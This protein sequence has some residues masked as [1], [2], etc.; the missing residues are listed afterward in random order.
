MGIG[1]VRAATVRFIPTNDAGAGL[2]GGGLTYVLAKVELTN[3]TPRDFTPDVRRFFLTSAQSRRYQGT[4]SGSSVFVGVSN[5]HRLLKQGETRD[6][7][8][9]FPTADPVITGTVSYEP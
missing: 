9:G 3:S 1:D 2:A 6:Y 4:D 7:T 8:V 5:S